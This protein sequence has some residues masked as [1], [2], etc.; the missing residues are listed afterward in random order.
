MKAVALILALAVITG[1]N[2][3]AIRQAEAT[4]NP[5][6][7]TVDRF[8]QYIAELGQNADG[9]V[10]N[11]KDSQLSRELDTLITA[12]MA[13]LETYKD[14]IQTK[15]VPYT[16]TST[17]QLSQDI[18]LLINR[19][20]KDML[21]AKERGTEYHRELQ[22][23]VDHNT[24]DIHGRLNTF[25]HKLQKRLNK[26]TEEI[27]N[28]VTTYMSEIQSRAAQNL[29]TVREHVEPYVQQAGDNTNKKLSDISAVLKSQAE[30]LGQQLE[31]QAEG[32]KTQLEATAQE[33]RTSLEGKIEE[34]TE[35]LSPY[36]TKIREQFEEIADKVKESTTA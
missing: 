24:D 4:K 18:Q 17:A 27:R 15:L 34:L 6:E 25:I 1:C 12:T 20:Q 2:A 22:A 30:G 14:N 21:D 29:D 3:R 19:L 26:D 8:W 33:L 10:Q 13:E 11:L 23:M 32:I 31:T 5:W 36:A 28:T 9:V 7:E 16:E 35:L